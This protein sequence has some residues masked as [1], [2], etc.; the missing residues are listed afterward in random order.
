MA[1]KQMEVRFGGGGETAN[2]EGIGVIPRNEWVPITAEQA[3]AYEAVNG[4]TIQNSMLQW[5]EVEAP[6][7]AKGQATKKAPA[8]KPGK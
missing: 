8:K 2:I 6:A 3:K 1:N 4:C 5:R 7:P